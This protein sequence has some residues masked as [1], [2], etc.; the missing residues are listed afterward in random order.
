[1][2]TARISRPSKSQL[3]SGDAFQKLCW[4]VLP[5]KS[6][7]PTPPPN[8]TF[9]CSLPSLCFSSV[10]GFSFAVFP[11]RIV[12]GSRPGASTESSEP[13]TVW[14][15]LWEEAL[16]LPVQAQTPL[17]G[18]GTSKTVPSPSFQQTP[19]KRPPEFAFF[20]GKTTFLLSTINDP[21]DSVFFGS[22]EG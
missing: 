22:R 16:A 11:R 5:K 3:S 2:T 17:F 10:C 1:M 15:R 13:N 7:L 21:C 6:S 4:F 9:V 14:H 8:S 12:T 20:W 18:Q 19:H